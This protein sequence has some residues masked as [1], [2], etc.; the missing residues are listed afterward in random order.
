LIGQVDFT[1]KPTHLVADVALSG[2][3]VQSI[4]THLPP[5]LRGARGSMSVSGHFEA[6]GLSQE[7]LSESLEGHATVVAS[8]VTLA[9]FDPVAAFVRLAGQGTLEPLRTPVWLR[10]LT[11]NFLLHD[12]RLVLKKTTLDFSGARLSL[13]GTQAFGGPADLHVTADLQRLRRRWL[14]RA[15]EVDTGASLREL[16]FSG[17]LDKLVPVSHA[18]ISSAQEK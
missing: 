15:D 11:L 16:E 2:A 8:D 10:S 6:T 4:V 13:S 17:S 1:A 18:E 3:A 9:G 12:R 5:A 14:N 7:E